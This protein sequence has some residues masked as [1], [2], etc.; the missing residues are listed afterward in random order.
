MNNYFEPSNSNL[1]TEDFSNAKGRLRKKLKKAFRDAG[2]YISDTAKKAGKKIGDKYGGGIAVHAANKINPV[3]IGLRG[4]MKSLLKNNVMGLAKSF[5]LIKE[6]DSAQ[7]DRLRQKF[8]MWGGDKNNFDKAVEA[9]KNKKPL[10]KP[11]LDKLR[12]SKGGD[13]QEE[14]PSS[15]GQEVA[16][17]IRDTFLLVKAISMIP[18]T[19]V[20]KAVSLALKATTFGLKD[21]GGELKDFSAKNGATDLE[22][23]KIPHLPIQHKKH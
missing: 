13:D 19:P 17:S 2:K 7:W 22:V 23:D 10:M 9:G 8:W 3:F 1:L 20:T 14:A 12:K 16:R 15:K 21:M 4:G 18:P 6:T 5:S 11:L